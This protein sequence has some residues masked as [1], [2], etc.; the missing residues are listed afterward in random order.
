MRRRRGLRG[1]LKEETELGDRVSLKDCQAL[2]RL[3]ASAS[4]LS[5]LMV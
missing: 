2:L 4:Q 5:R 1:P 3:A